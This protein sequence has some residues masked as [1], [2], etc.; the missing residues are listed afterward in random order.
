MQH[1]LFDTDGVI[2]HSDM[3]SLEYARRSGISSEYMRPFFTGVFQECIL[4]RADLKSE[5]ESF[6]PQ[7]RYTG[8]ADQYLSEWFHYEHHLDMDLIEKIQKIR[9]S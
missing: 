7:W 2:V 4:G 3:W 6:L 1:I 8:G 9:K 5:I